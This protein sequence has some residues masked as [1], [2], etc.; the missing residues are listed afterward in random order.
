MNNSHQYGPLTRIKKFFLPTKYDKVQKKLF[1][2]R[3]YFYQQ[4]ISPGT[5]CFDIG[6]NYGNRTEIFLKLQA[7][8]VALEPQQK[9][10]DFL[11]KK[12]GSRAIVLKKGAGAQ[13]GELDFFI[14]DGN[15]QV[16]TFS[17]DWINEF[18]KSRF[19]RNEWNRTEKIKL[20][21]LDSLVEEYGEPQFIKIDVEGFEPDVL[22]GLSKPFQYLS[23]E[24]AV[25]EK[26]DNLLQCL[27]ILHSKYKNLSANYAIGEEPKL[28]LNSWISLNK[29]IE[30]VNQEKFRDSF[31]GDIYIKNT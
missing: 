3:V 12:F 15:P 19:S 29:M 1:H 7:K 11:T 27:S 16:S 23:F 10:Y 2:D 13:I 4:F 30:Y 24:Y 18:K 31:A 6:A 14:N 20:V 21:T 8:V 22:L 5:L 17:K 25:P 28:Q 9:C 26:I